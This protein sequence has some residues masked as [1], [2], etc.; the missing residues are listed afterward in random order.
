MACQRSPVAISTASMS[1]RSARK[2]ADLRVHCAVLVAVVAVHEVLDRK[3]LLLLKIANGDELHV[4]LADERL[5]VVHAAV[6]DADAPQ[7]DLLAGRD[8]PVLPQ[9]GRRHDR[10]HNQD[11]ARRAVDLRNFRRVTFVFRMLIFSW[12]VALVLTAARAGARWEQSRRASPDRNCDLPPPP[13]QPPAE[14][15]SQA[16]ALF[17][18]RAGR[19][20]CRV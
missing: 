10:R 13:M 14:N 8:G 3:T 20:T 15:F 19:V 12:N 6:L 11:R 7:D 16:T 5:E 17:L 18:G 9:H 4:G 2:A 1:V